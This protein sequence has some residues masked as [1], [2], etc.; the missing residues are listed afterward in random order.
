MIWFPAGLQ[1]MKLQQHLW[2][3]LVCTL[4]WLNGPRCYSWQ[5]AVFDKRGVSERPIW[6]T[7][8]YCLLREL[9]HPPPC[10]NSSDGVKDIDLVKATWTCISCDCTRIWDKLCCCKCIEKSQLG[11]IKC[12]RPERVLIIQQQDANIASVDCWINNNAECERFHVRQ[13]TEA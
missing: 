13:Y 5:I 6:H 8:H 2:P 10:T 9:T 4:R 3:H 7:V 11:S 12:C 1:W